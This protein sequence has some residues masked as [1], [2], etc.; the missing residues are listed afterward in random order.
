MI[1][2]TIELRP[3]DK[4]E[5]IWDCTVSGKYG[6]AKLNVPETFVTPLTIKLGLIEDLKDILK[7]VHKNNKTT[8]FV[9]QITGDV[10]YVKTKKVDTWFNAFLDIAE[11]D[12]L[13]SYADVIDDLMDTLNDDQDNAE[14]PEIELNNDQD[15]AEEL[16]NELNNEE[17]T[18]MENQPITLAEIDNRLT[19]ALDDIDFGETFA[20]ISKYMVQEESD[21]IPYQDNLTDL[22]L[23]HYDSFNG[24]NKKKAK[25]LLNY[26]KVG[27]HE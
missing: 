9:D 26:L 6:T 22:I 25:S 21:E 19:K 15:N 3:A 14:K 12:I 1:K 24:V 2:Q 7:V 20:L 10:F 8:E 27:Y 5:S 4:I 23:K 16:V 13:Q 17:D 18:T 11:S